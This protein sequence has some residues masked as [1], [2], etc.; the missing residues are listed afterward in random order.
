MEIPIIHFDK[1][2]VNIGQIIVRKTNKFITYSLLTRLTIWKKIWN[3]NDA[4]YAWTASNS[5]ES[6]RRNRPS[7]IYARPAL[8]IL[9]NAE[10]RYRYEENEERNPE[11]QT[12]L[13]SD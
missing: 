2:K 1:P 5:S 8:H 7:D 12:E 4:G 10:T 11:T 6:E 9:G 13:K 3:H